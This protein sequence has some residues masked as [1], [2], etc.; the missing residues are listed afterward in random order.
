MVD[1]SPH[2]PRPEGL[3]R[4]DVAAQIVESFGLGDL[5]AEPRAV[6]RGWQ[7][8]IWRFETSTGSYAVKELLQRLTETDAALD[9]AF[10][11]AVLAGGGAKAPRPIRTRA[12]TVLADIDRRQVRVH[13]WVDLLP[14]DK[15]LDPTLVG[16]TVGAIHRVHMAAR[17][18]VHPWYVEPVG[19]TRWASLRDA[20]PAVGA[21][22]ADR[23]AVAVPDFLALETLFEEPRELQVCH[24]DLFA[25]NLLA[26]PDGV[27]CA[28]DWENCGAEDP[29][30]ELAVVLTEFAVGQPERSRALVEAYR[31]AGGTGRLLSR[32]SFTMVLAQFGHFF[33]SSALT[34]LD[35]ASTEED[36]QRAIARFDEVVDAMLTVEHIDEMIGAASDI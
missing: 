12:G 16:A 21:P 4:R 17:S 27:L 13:E 15:Q 28:I 20:L 32:G 7:G 23:F 31:Q 2:E 9:A 1:S 19:G 29:A 10:A 36:R 18:P 14:P 11:D 25:D 22:F 30:H 34:W 33:Q 24:C 26:T 35:P 5:L 6:A 8:R 3:G